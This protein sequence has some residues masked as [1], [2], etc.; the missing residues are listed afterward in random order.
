MI[1]LWDYFM[2]SKTRLQNCHCSLVKN[3]CYLPQPRLFLNLVLWIY[4]TIIF[5]IG[6]Y[7]SALQ[8]SV[9]CQQSIKWSNSLSTNSKNY[10]YIIHTNT[11]TINLSWSRLLLLQFSTSVEYQLVPVS[12]FLY[13]D[14]LNYSSWYL[15]GHH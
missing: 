3:S 11:Q 15:D 7:R 12:F 14:G 9:D 4:N 1:V 6:E 5:F 13:L 8:P 2:T 10:V